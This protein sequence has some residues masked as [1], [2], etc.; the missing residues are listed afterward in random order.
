[1]TTLD[2]VPVPA[3]RDTAERVARL[4]AAAHRIRRHALD[5]GEVQGQGY[6]GQALGIA[7][8]LAVVYGDQLRFRHAEPEWPGRDRFLL[9]IG[10]GSRGRR[11]A[12][13]P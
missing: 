4:E 2:T 6:I 3:T 13:A 12:R 8:V 10:H 5:M 9:S 7:D 11:G 1:M